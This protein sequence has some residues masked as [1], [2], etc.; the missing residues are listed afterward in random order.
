MSNGSLN[1]SVN[2]CLVSHEKTL[3]AVQ[4]A[5]QAMYV[6]KE[7]DLMLRQAQCALMDARDLLK[8]ARDMAE[9]YDTE[10]PTLRT[11]AP[12][13]TKRFSVARATA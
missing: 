11:G 4:E 8:N 2:E 1:E 3:K 6:P 9:D 13:V 12:L 5:R 10:P 7:V